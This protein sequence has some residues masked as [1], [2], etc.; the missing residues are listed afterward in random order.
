MDGAVAPV[1][2]APLLTS[3][4]Q[5][6][7]SSGPPLLP[8]IR[9][10]ERSSDDFN[11]PTQSTYAPAVTQVKEE[12]VGGVAAHLDYEMD[13]MVDFVSEMAQGMYEIFASK[14]CLADIDM[15]RSVLS[16]KASPHRDFR[17]YVSQVLSSTR[18][19]SSTILC[20][21][22]YLSK[23]MTLL[24]N[25]GRYGQG[26]R[27]TYSML[28]T[29]LMLGSK[30]LDDNTFQNRSW[31]EVSN[32]PVSDLNFLE[33]QWLVDINWDMH[34]DQSDPEGLSLW[35]KTWDKYHS[36]NEDVSLAA[37]MRQ[38]HIE[39]NGQQ[40]LQQ[41]PVPQLP[42][43]NTQYLHMQP[44]RSSR[45]SFTSQGSWDT[46]RHSHWQQ[47]RSQ[48]NYS[49]PSA[50]ET[51]PNTPDACNLLNAY[52]YAPQPV[53]PTFKLPASLHMLPLSASHSGYP[54]PYTPKYSHYGHGS[55]CDCSFCRSHYERYLM[56][57][58]YGPQ[59]MA[60]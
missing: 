52:A 57:P 32:I 31:S 9:A 5:Y 15:T 46:P 60:A 6:G 50:P 42:P 47:P 34:I 20:G 14:I 55:C 41:R 53:H 25:N 39:N 29:A 58:G 16:S 18:L 26:T 38:T 54:T 51:G 28:T 13:E 35:L 8:P 36:R 56:A 1:F 40:K 43:L 2:P 49:P 4:N 44:D 10:P 59:P 19:P 23:R 37:S 7:P 12:K 33:I 48:I 24:S 11:R 17:K 45:V 30:F 27:D 3:S 22:M 21:L